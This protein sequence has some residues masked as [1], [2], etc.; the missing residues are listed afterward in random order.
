MRGDVYS[1]PPQRTRL[2]RHHLL[3]SSSG[4]NVIIVSSLPSEMIL[5]SSACVLTVRSVVSILKL[6]VLTYSVPSA[7]CSDRRWVAMLYSTD[8]NCPASRVSHKP[9]GAMYTR[10]RE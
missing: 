3:L 2:H 9:S 6:A 4:A 5:L 1:N 10:W 8:L 7:R